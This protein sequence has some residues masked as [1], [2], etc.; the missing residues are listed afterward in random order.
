MRRVPGGV[1]I[2][3][4]LAAVCVSAGS[5]A[6]SVNHEL[7]INGFI[8]GKTRAA[9]ERAY[10]YLELKQLKFALGLD[11][12]SEHSAYPETSEA[13]RIVL[14][15][16]LSWSPQAASA[17]TL[18]PAFKPGPWSF[19]PTAQSCEV[20]GQVATCRAEG[21]PSGT[22]LFGW[23]FDAVASKPGT[24][25]I[26]GEVVP[27]SD[28]QNRSPR[29][30]S[31]PV[32]AVLTLVIG[33]R[34]GAVKAGGV[35]LTRLRPSFVKA[36]IEVTQGGVGVQATATSCNGSFAGDASRRKLLASV[37]ALR[38]SVTCTFVFNNAKYVGKNLLGELSFTVAKTKITRK[39]SV[40]VGPGTTLNSPKG[41]TLGQGGR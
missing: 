32:R 25:K 36:R 27:P 13:I 9:S 3:A 29:G 39:F 14:P 15:A 37:L 17:Q 30:A 7:G 38:G 10:S 4:V 34:T 21:V 33:P 40:R 28:G 19:E 24:Y 12:L 8:V 35:V 18:W 5:A 2:F 20:S 23:I 26:T 31:T 22:Q 41:A 6:S 1:V 11:L 16:G